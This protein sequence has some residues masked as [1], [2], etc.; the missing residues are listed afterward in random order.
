LGPFGTAAINM[1]TVPATGDYEDGEMGEKY[2]FKV[3]FS[4]I[5]PFIPR[6]S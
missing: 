5:L 3:H 2:S 4:V 1:P 6:N